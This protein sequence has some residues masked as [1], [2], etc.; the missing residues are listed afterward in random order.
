MVGASPLFILY[1]SGVLREGAPELPL[2]DALLARLC[3]GFQESV[4][5][6]G[7]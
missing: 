5:L 2:P 7:R 6:A 1:T 3:S 4:Q